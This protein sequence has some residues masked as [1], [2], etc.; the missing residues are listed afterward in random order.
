MW[1]TWQCLRVTCH[2]SPCTLYSSRLRWTLPCVALGVQWRVMART[3]GAY[4]SAPVPHA[5]LPGTG[6]L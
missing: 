5:G 3:R 4:A 1:S 6:L 2:T